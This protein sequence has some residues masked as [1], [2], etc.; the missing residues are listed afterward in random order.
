M[1]KMLIQK[2][3][4]STMGETRI[5][6]WDPKVQN[7]KLPNLRTIRRETNSNPICKM[8]VLMNSIDVST[9]VIGLRLDRQLEV[10]LAESTQV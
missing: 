6:R 1:E 10:T 8:K 5:K 4:Q 9:V 3:V 2:S 7:H